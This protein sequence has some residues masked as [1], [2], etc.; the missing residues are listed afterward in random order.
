MTTALYVVVIVVGITALYFLLE[1]L[2]R[3]FTKYRGARVVTCPETNKPAGV[4]VDAVSAALSKGLQLKECSRWPERQDCGQGCLKQIEAAPED[5]LVRNML[6]KWY[7]G[8]KCAFCGRPLE[9]LD[10][11]EHSPALMA[12]DK[13]TLKWREVAPE[14]VPE[15]LATHL[16]VCWNCHIA[17]TFRREHPDLVTERP[18]TK[19]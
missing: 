11:A 4:E 13:R 18:W 3:K 14:Q 9:D 19:H 10:W 5:C 15:A 6:T 7:A 17:A 16:P 12:P 1:P 8:K 2:I